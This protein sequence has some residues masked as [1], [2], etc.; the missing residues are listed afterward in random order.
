MI[1]Y[2]GPY[3]TVC[4]DW[5][6]FWTYL[7]DH[8]SEQTSFGTAQRALLNLAQ[9][10]QTNNVGQ[11]GATAPAN[12]GGSDSLLSGGNEYLHGQAYG[13]AIDNQGNADCETGQR[14]YPRSSTTTTRS[15]AIWPPTRTRPVTRARP[16]P[17]G[18][19]A[20]GRDVQP[21]PAHRPAACRRSRATP[22]ETQERTQEDEA[23]TFAA[24]AIGIVVIVVFSYG[25]YSKFANPFASQYTIHAVF[26]NANGLSARVAGADRRR[27][28][29]QGDGRRTEPGCKSASKTPTACQAADVAMT[30]SNN[31]LPIHNDAT[32]AI[33]PRIFLEGNFFVDVSPGTP[34]A[35]TARDGHTFPIQQGVEPVQLDQVLTSL[36]AD[37]RQ[38]LQTLLQQYGKAVNESGAVVQPLDPVLAAGLRVHARWSPTTRSACSRTTSPTTSPRR[39]TVA[40]AL[41]AHPQNLK[42]LVTDFNTT[43]NAFAPR[44]RGAAQHG[45]PAAAGPCRRRRRRSTR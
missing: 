12:G 1:R 14:G 6:Y 31:G 4:D 16:S 35:P 15:T 29:R 9:P 40:G 2:L 17:A 36:Q 39:A 20:Q 11:Q 8:V 28:C 26:S 10:T 18:P 5:N 33:R 23:S 43:A 45:H 44:E 34:S 13:A 37:T 41:D 22:D 19:R 42:N 24:G 30:I 25:A 32:F 7:S 3:Q 27:Q 21:Q 38:N